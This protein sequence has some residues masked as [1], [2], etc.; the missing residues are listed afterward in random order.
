[1][2]AVP[3]AGLVQA[4]A[5]F[6]ACTSAQLGSEP[7]SVIIQNRPLVLFRARGGAP[8]AL[9]DR[10]PHRNVPL[11]IGRVRG[12]ELECAYHG[13]RF[14][15]GGQCVAVPGLV[16]GEVSLKSRCAEHF[17]TRELDGF[18]WVYSTSGADEPKEGPFRFPHLDDRAYSTVRR[19]FKVAASLHAAVENTLDVPHTAFL[20]GGL[21]RTEEKKNVIDVVVRRH[22]RSAEAHFHGEPAPRGLVG[23]LL[24]PQG[25]VVEHVDRFLLPCIAQVEYRLGARSHVVATTAFTPVNDDACLVFAVVT[26]T[27]P[28]P[29]WLVRPFVAPVAA[30]IFAQDAVVLAKQRE[31]IKL[32]GGEKYTSTELDVLGPQI[33]RLLKQAAAGEPAEEHEHTLQMK[34]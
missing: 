21:F 33:T 23:W 5:W 30:R 25:G 27:L 1:V 34:T 11:S 7:L 2:S 4:D 19:E 10:C 9:I 6:I 18:V 20:H 3:P 15:G 31:Q 24:A 8:S 26:Y 28:V 29:G 32:F 14:D 16:S 22:A 17:A 12:G 13:W